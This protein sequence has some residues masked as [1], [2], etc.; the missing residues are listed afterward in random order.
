MNVVDLSVKR[1]QGKDTLE[2]RSSILSSGTI[3]EVQVREDSVPVTEHWGRKDGGVRSCL[4]HLT[5]FYL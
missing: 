4:V 3:P 2:R 5:H 1:G